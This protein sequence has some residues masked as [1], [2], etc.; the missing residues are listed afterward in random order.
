MVKKGNALVRW[1]LD[2]LFVTS[3]KQ[4]LKSPSLLTFKPSK[5]SGEVSKPLL[6]SQSAL[7]IFLGVQYWLD[8]GPL[9]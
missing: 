2:V 5:C 8:L 4:L 9:L 1:S 7:T 6:G 3:G